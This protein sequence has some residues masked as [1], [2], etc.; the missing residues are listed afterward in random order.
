MHVSFYN[1]APSFWFWG[2]LILMKPPVLHSFHI[3][4]SVFWTSTPPIYWRATLSQLF[5]FYC[6]FNLSLYCFLVESI[7]LISSLPLA[8]TQILLPFTKEKFS[9]NFLCLLSL[10]PHLQVT[11][12]PVVIRLLFPTLL[13][14]YSD[15]VTNIILIV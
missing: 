9:E 1:P 10:L 5:S 14:N 15:K 4:L 6:V 12:Q 8:S 13:W 11:S 7:S 3:I 2:L